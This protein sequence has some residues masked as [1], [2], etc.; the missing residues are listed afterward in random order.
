MSRNPQMR[1]R[2]NAL[3]SQALLRAQEALAELDREGCNVHAIVLR[4]H[5]PVLLIEPPP[6][7]FAGMVRLHTNSQGRREAL[8][9]AEVAGCRVEWTAK[10]L[11]TVPALTPA[12]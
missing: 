6:G 11:Q 4:D 1:T 8:W 5:R 7:P 10:P 2:P 9:A 3:M 12:G